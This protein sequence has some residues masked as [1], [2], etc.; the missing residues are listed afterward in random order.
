[1]G[2]WTTRLYFPPQI[3]IFSDGCATTVTKYS[4]SIWL[5]V[6]LRFTRKD[7]FLF[8]FI[9]N[10]KFRSYNKM[11]FVFF[12]LYHIPLVFSTCM[13]LSRIFLSFPVCL[14][15]LYL[16]SEARRRKTFSNLQDITLHRLVFSK[17]NM[18][19]F[20]SFHLLNVDTTI[21]S[22]LQMLLFLLIVGKY[23]DQF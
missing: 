18:T 7:S 4:F 10:D 3:L 13:Y 20:R 12:F 8:F 9:S 19:E 2:S 16:L 23:H 17:F 21:K 22:T 14:E 6:F 1:M 15:H 11:C 5:L